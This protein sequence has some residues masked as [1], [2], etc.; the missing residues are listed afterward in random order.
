MGRLLNKIK[1]TLDPE[2]RKEKARA[3]AARDIAQIKAETTRLK[4]QMA[5]QKPLID[6]HTEKAKAEAD[7]L[8]A[9]ARLAKQRARVG[10]YKGGSS[11]TAAGRAGGFLKDMEEAM[12]FNPGGG[13]MG[14]GMFRDPFAPPPSKKKR[15]KKRR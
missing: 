13:G 1:A 7:L 4:A 9:R 6:A 11:S 2:V 5:S 15:S 10:K 14:A 8:K 12:G 3:R